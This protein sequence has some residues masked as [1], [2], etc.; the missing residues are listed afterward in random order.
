MRVQAQSLDRTIQLAPTQQWRR[1]ELEHALGDEARL[2]Q[3][4]LNLIENAHKYS[5]PALPIQVRLIKHHHTLILEV[6]DRGIGIPQADQAQVFDRFHRGSNTAGQSG[7]GIGLSVVQLL[8]KAMGGNI[9]VTS[10][11]GMG[12]CFRI[13][14]QEAA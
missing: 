3:V 5:P 11:P 8:V 4:L 10:E 14:L 13:E 6:E 2:H 7:S 9:S 1:S 12:S